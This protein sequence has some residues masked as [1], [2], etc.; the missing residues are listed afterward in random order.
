MRCDNDK[1]SQ[2]LSPEPPYRQICGNEVIFFE[3]VMKICK[4]VAGG[5]IDSTEMPAL[6]L[7]LERKCMF[8]KHTD[9]TLPQKFIGA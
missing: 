1:L 7:E 2:V 6:I 5:Y 8:T 3:R 9:P 4:K